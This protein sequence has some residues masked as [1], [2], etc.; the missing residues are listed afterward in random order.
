MKQP[1]A[2]GRATETVRTD[3][4]DLDLLDAREFS[5]LSVL[6]LDSVRDALS[7]VEDDIATAI[8]LVHSSLSQGGRLIYVGAG[9]PGRIGLLDASE[10]PPTF[11]TEPDTVIALIAGGLDAVAAAVEGAEDDS[12]AGAADLDATAVGPLDTVVGISASGETP[13]VRGALE[14]ATARGAM[15]I[16]VVS[17]YGSTLAGLAQHSIEAVV[18]PEIVAGSTRL[19]AGTA[20]KVI[21][22]A[23][24]TGSMVR[25]GYVYG[26]WM[27]GVQPTNTKLRRRAQRMVE[28]IAGVQAEEA[29]A[30]LVGAGWN[31]RIA[32]LQLILNTDV[33]SA[34]RILQEH[35]GRVRAALAAEA[36]S[37]AQGKA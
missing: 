3:V 35:N 25:L 8:N 29:H 30:V 6:E 1:P 18:G 36:P 21:L 9:T 11:G 15:T 16:A 20:Q 12:S 5:R 37:P 17:S 2:E 19:K 4:P 26:P 33:T 28:V 13:Y 24:S 23:I 7:A 32:V 10:C 27:V 22:N 31:V 14:R 34:S